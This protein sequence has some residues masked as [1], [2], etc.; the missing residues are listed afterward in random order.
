LALAAP[1]LQG[2]HSNT[3]QRGLDV[4]LNSAH[5]QGVAARVAHAMPQHHWHGGCGLRG[6]E[7]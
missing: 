1:D 4:L 7:A 3:R 2:Q 6:G 5:R